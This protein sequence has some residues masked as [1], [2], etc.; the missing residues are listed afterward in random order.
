MIVDDEVNVLSALKRE[1]TAVGY[2]V[3][4]FAKGDEALLQA[5]KSQYDLV[6]SDYRMPQMNGV[7]FL[8]EFKVLQPQ[9]ARLIL[10]G[11]ADFN[12]L[13]EAVN[14][15]EI[16]RFISKPWHSEE[17]KASIAQ[18]LAH[19]AILLENQKLADLVRSQQDLLDKH[20]SV[21]ERLEA[22]SPGITKVNWDKDGCI[23]LAEEGG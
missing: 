21:L 4:V 3:N 19:Q 18:A 2:V 16:F 12:A 5:H 13:L 20:R 9:A 6:I 1:L 15:A 14:Q 8:N 23:I 10:S 11:Y 17:L 7:E 22:E